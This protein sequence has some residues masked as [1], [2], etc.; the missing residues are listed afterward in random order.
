MLLSSKPRRFLCTR[1]HSPDRDPSWTLPAQVHR[2]AASPSAP[3]RGRTMKE[4]IEIP[5][6]SQNA[7][8]SMLVS[9]ALRHSY[10][11]CFDIVM[12]AVRLRLQVAEKHIIATCIRKL[13]FAF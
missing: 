1:R 6:Q 10:V 7:S 5:P 13:E 2:P 3:G 12:Q 9:S 11:K 4:Q 8:S